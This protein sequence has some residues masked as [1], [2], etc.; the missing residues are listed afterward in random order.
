MCCILLIEPSRASSATFLLL[1]FSLWNLGEIHVS[2]LSLLK[3]FAGATNLDSE[4]F[5][6]NFNRIV[7]IPPS[8]ASEAKL[9]QIFPLDTNLYPMI[10]VAEHLRYVTTRGWSFA[11]QILANYLGAE[12]VEAAYSRLEDDLKRELLRAV[13]N[14]WSDDAR[15]AAGT[16]EWEQAFWAL[17]AA[18]AEFEVLCSRKTVESPDVSRPEP[19]NPGSEAMAE[20]IR[21]FVRPYAFRHWAFSTGWGGFNND[22]VNAQDTLRGFS[23]SFQGLNSLVSSLRQSSLAEGLN[24]G[25]TMITR[26]QVLVFINPT[27]EW[28]R[29]L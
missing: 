28:F 7:S 29:I 20:L 25:L 14:L 21:Q 15:T 10:K 3:M 22:L 17:F 26:C 12:S 18:G 1:Y 23:F 8:P 16:G 6:E 2:E 5:W 19:E 24:F 11:P 27:D 4:L 9:K 13:L